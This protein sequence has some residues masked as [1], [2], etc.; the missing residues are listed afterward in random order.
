M[1]SLSLIALIAVA[2]VDSAFAVVAAFAHKTP[3]EK[4]SPKVEN[5]IKSKNEAATTAV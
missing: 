5:Q 1:T 2:V 3:V 4:M